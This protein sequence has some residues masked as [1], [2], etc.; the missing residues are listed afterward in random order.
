MVGSD[1]LRHKL[2]IYGLLGLIVAFHVAGSLWWIQ[3]NVTLVGRDATGHLGRTLVAANAPSLFAALTFTDDYR[4]P[5]LY[6]ATVPFYWLFGVNMDS[7]QYTN[8][9]VLAALLLVTFGLARRL[10]SAEAALL[11]VALTGLLPM[12]TA[13]SRLFYMENLLTMLLLLNL[14]ALLQSDGFGNRIWSLG[15][16]ISLGLA[17]LAKWTA[18]I[19]VALPTLY[20]LWIACREI[21][22]SGARIS[23]A[24]RITVWFGTLP[25]G[26]QPDWRRAT[27]ALL[28]SMILV[29]W[30]WW[31][32]RE[33]VQGLFFGGWLPVLWFILFAVSIYLL[34]LPATRSANF[35]GALL[36]AL[37]L[38]S[39]WYL[40]HINFMTRLTDVAFGTD[41]G[42]QEAFDPTRASNYTRY[43]GYWFSYYMGLL[44]TLAILPPALW[45]EI[46]ARRR[47]HRVDWTLSA[48]DPAHRTLGR[49]ILW[50]ALVSAFVILTLIAQATP[51][52]LNPLW[53][54]IAILLVDSL[55]SYSRVMALALASLWLLV[56]GV[57]WLIFTI[58]DLAP[59]HQRT[60]VLW[61]QE[62]Y[63]A[64]PAAGSS[65][66]GFW[67][68]P[69]V[70]AMVGNPQDRPATLGMLVNSWEI[71]RG[72]F[73]YLIAAQHLNIELMPLT[74]A[75]G[76]TWSD[77]LTNQWVLVKDGDNSEVSAAGQAMIARIAAG[78]PIFHLLYQAAKRY[79]LP[80]GETATLYQRV[81]GPERPTDYPVVLIE[82]EAI[83]DAINRYW[84]PG[85]TL[86]FSRADTA[87]WV[88]FHDLKVDRIV[89]LASE[90][91]S[92]QTELAETTG[93]I[94]AATR[95]DTAEVQAWLS[96][97]SYPA[98]E[99]GSGEFWL[100]IVGRPN[101]PL[102]AMPTH[103]RW[104]ELTI[105]TVQS[106][107][108]LQP[109]QVLPVEMT[110]AGRTDSAR[111][112]SIRLLDPAGQVVA[113]Q[114]KAIEPHL[115]LGLLL[116]PA[117]L[118]GDY[119]LAAV[120]YD[121]ATLQP[122]PD[123]EGREL[124][125]VTPLVV[126]PSW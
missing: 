86:F 34:S 64:W 71:H 123:M 74:D 37:S 48:T 38:A 95:Y 83:A 117:A 47:A 42:T 29:G 5:L 81:L 85:A 40:P 120:L 97:T 79:P 103:T 68:Q 100:T 109:G 8:V 35:W 66:P 18:P 88:G 98:L 78:D 107:P 24:D 32:Q 57:Q 101:R 60:S 53:P 99:V 52:N 61:V 108:T 30:W 96:A 106:F 111:K 126:T 75:D 59:L 62:G 43:F 11:A 63:S 3:R 114:D 115:R 90:A 65:D 44:A 9:V 36:L 112:L 119:T 10:L 14:L 41:R 92:V 17:L 110:L 93:V 122:V 113:Q 49:T 69:D 15:W 87:A 94:M 50:L 105:T 31:P 45:G 118:P 72:S 46:R 21:G 28:L 70:L 102:V 27:V 80:N 25:F 2:L 73:R 7:A 82:T 56:L 77:L 19:Y 54:L 67:I 124:A 121:P 20:V 12:I 23:M 58:D 1:S 22:S 39:L 89:T 51:R 104:P 91:E 116:P 6:L 16:G 4:P 55:R 125:E 76:R 13:M 84:S 33:Q 26:R